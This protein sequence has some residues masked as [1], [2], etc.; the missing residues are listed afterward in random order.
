MI[1]APR[2]S[3]ATLACEIAR[4]SFS[5]LITTDSFIFRQIN[6]A[7]FS[8]QVILC[9]LS[10]LLW[11]IVEQRS[12][13]LAKARSAPA[14]FVW[15]IGVIVMFIGTA[16]RLSMID[17][18]TGVT[19]MECDTSALCITWS[20]F[21]LAS[22]YF[23]RAF[24]LLSKAEYSKMVQV[25]SLHI[26]SAD[27]Q[28]ATITHLH[29]LTRSQS[30][31]S[32]RNKNFLVIDEEE[33]MDNHNNLITNLPSVM[34]SVLRFMRL[35]IGVKTSNSDQ[36]QVN[37]TLAHIKAF[38]EVKVIISVGVLLSAPGAI[39]GTIIIVTSSPIYQTSC[40][41][42]DI[43][44]DV[45]GVVIGTAAFY[46]ALAFRVLYLVKTLVK[47]SYGVLREFLLIPFVCGGPIIIGGLLL[48]FDPGQV[49][50][51]RIFSWEWIILFGIFAS[52]FVM[53]PLQLYFGLSD[54]VHKMFNGSWY[55]FGKAILTCAEIERQPGGTGSSPSPK[56]RSRKST[57]M[58]VP[59]NTKQRMVP[60]MTSTLSINPPQ[61]KINFEEF[62]T[63]RFCGESQRFLDD[64]ASYNL[65]CGEKADNWKLSKSKL[66]YNTYLAGDA[67]LQ[68]NVS[69]FVR[70]NCEANIKAKKY[71]GV[72]DE[73][74]REVEDLMQFDVWYDFVMDGGLKTF[75]IP[76]EDVVSNN[77][78]NMGNSNNVSLSVVP[79]SDGV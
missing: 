11:V 40:S 4:S 23:M 73:A 6:L 54:Y 65:F 55:L 1:I 41:G 52:W 24:V 45:A 19:T 66:I 50:A 30:K 62:L 15:C 64:C 2:S 39:I 32:N 60:K 79:T 51:Q 63:S 76:V 26:D 59:R 47:E 44:V 22:A 67:P 38:G 10:C 70:T 8:T 28:T 31:R 17:D 77:N 16:L 18:S 68:I 69:D 43:T 58:V 75:K 27:D 5:T 20:F 34:S 57:I 12:S 49:D 53:I 25:F 35:I 21:F 61:L 13:Y 46:C 72:F 78:N 48:V 9:I 14:N 7:L 56:R 71:I 36:D 37:I 74:M 42:C 33:L 3:N 29:K